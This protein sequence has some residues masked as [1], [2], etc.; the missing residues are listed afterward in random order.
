M[1]D[2]GSNPVQ[3]STFRKLIMKIS[4]YKLFKRLDRIFDFVIKI[5]WFILLCKWLGGVDI[6]SLL[7]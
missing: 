3:C 6:I 2:A 4:T 7:K 1:E 5:L